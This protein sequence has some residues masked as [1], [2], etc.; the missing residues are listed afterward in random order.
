VTAGRAVTRARAAGTKTYAN[1]VGGV[2]P[3]QLMHSFG[4]WAMVDLPSISVI[5]AGLDDWKTDFAGDVAED[6]L[7]ENGRG[8]GP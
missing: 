8:Q 3:S 7:P 2:R 5:V 6:R 4:V 1:R